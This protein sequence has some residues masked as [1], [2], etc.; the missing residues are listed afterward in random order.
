MPVGQPFDCDGMASLGCGFF[1]GVY[2][3][4]VWCLSGMD[5]NCFVSSDNRDAGLCG[6]ARGWSGCKGIMEVSENIGGVKK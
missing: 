5:K 2:G 6:S 3:Y 1:D 4:V